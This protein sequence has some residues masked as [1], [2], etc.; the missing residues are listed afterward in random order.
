[1]CGRYV[2]TTP[3]EV[4]AQIFDT[5]P[6]PEELLAAIVPRYN[7]SP[8]QQVPIVRHTAAGPRELA[9]VHWGLVPHWAKDPV[10]GNRLIN[11]RAETAAEKPSFRDAMKRRRC[12]IPAD[13][14]YEWQKLGKGKQPFLLR[15][16]DGSTF[17]FAGL[18]SQWKNP[19]SG[20]NLETCAILTTTSNELAATVHDRMPVI[21]PPTTWNRWLDDAPQ[22]TPFTELLLSFPAEQLEAFPVS[23]RV[24]SPLHEGPENILPVE[25]AE[26]ATEN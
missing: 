16:R 21:L 15:L 14:F 6:P 24:N 3:G 18:W 7:I 4:L 8:T 13:G 5:A 11:A 9:L 20:A 12:L 17:A 22:S 19:E 23:K 1:M 10:I 26:T 25:L 2:L